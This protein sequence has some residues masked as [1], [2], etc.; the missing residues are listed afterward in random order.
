[1]SN[2]RAI[3]ESLAAVRALKPCATVVVVNMAPPTAEKVAELHRAENV[4][5]ILP[6][7]DWPYL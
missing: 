4:A 7:D 3:R 2:N 5:H 1:V 6:S